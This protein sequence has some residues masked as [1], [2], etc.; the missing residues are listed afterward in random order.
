MDQLAPSVVDRDR[1]SAIAHTGIAIANPIPAAVIDRFIGE[2]ALGKDD[3]LLDVGCGR[4]EL[5]IR[6]VERSGCAAVGIDQS[7]AQIA[8]ARAEAA[9]RV[10]GA[11]ITFH[12]AAAGAV[13]LELRS[14]RVVACVGSTHAYGGL[15][16]ALASL[17]MFLTPG[18]RLLVGDGYWTE[19]PSAAYLAGWGATA[20]ELP[21]LTQF[22]R[23]FEEHRLTISDEYLAT[24]ADWDAYEE[25]WLAN[26]DGHVREHPDD[27]DAPGMV[28]WA[29]ETRARRR[30]GPGV[31]GFA[32]VLATVAG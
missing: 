11:D 25:P 9:T 23:W 1:A 16:P 17:S 6:A 32:L 30:L 4:G 26:I 31:L 3:H 20:A 22:H 19:P 24:P 5:L 21:D 2:C 28:T 29:N 15:S 18:G 27:P 7:P 13:G 12:E 10:P 8:I 14:L